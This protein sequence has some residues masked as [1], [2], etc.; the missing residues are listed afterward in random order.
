[1]E[2]TTQPLIINVTYQLIGEAA[3]Q[4]LELKSE[5]CIESNAELGRSLMLKQMRRQLSSRRAAKKAQSKRKK[6]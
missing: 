6:A 2:Q 4:F 3:E 5:E 1:M